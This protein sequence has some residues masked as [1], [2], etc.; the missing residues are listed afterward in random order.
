MRASCI[1]GRSRNLLS[2]Q[3][4]KVDFYYFFLMDEISFRREDFRN[5]NPLAGSQAESVKRST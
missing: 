4:S 1:D 5:A 2:T 3:A